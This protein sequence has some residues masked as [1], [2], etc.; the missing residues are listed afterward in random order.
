[1]TPV[2][3]TCG[4]VVLQPWTEQDVD[5]CL[6][7]RTDPD[8]IRWTGTPVPYTRELAEKYVREQTPQWWEEGSAASWAVRHAT[9]GAVLGAVALHHLEDG[10]GEI[11]YWTMPEARG[12]GITTEAVAAVC[13]W[14]FGALEL[15][16]IVWAAAVG[17]WASRAVAQKV[18]FTYEGVSRKAY[19]QRGTRV[20]DWV[21]SLLSTDPM[22]DTRPLPAT[23]D[24]TDGVVALRRWRSEDAPDVARACDDPVTAHWLPVPV[25]YTLDHAQDYVDGF[26]RRL[27]A[28]GLSAE[29]AVVDALT[30]E[31]LG[32]C[33]LK[34]PHRDQGFG[35]IGY[36]TAPWA[37]GRGAAG[38]ATRLISSWGLEVLELD[39]VEL[40]ADVDNAASQRA[41]E[42]AGF[43]REGTARRSRRD[44]DGTS[45]DMAVFSRVLA[46]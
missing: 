13:R 23:L 31:L 38:R 9:T 1:M 32:A 3:I 17:N 30:G 24:L 29:T 36:W 11:A 22:Q 21:G 8:V 43:L 39:R 12:S 40:L 5:D 27:W 4:A 37:R 35:E 20:D 42:K 45:H 14:A 10:Q 16:R 2:D 19:N 6:R 25:P 18:G 46:D 7:G 41:A 28:D 15:E 44:R 26:T 33:G 34:V